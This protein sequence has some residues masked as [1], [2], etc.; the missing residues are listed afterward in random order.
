MTAITK[1]SP[2]NAAIAFL[3]VAGFVAY[4]AAF[5][6]FPMDADRAFRSWKNLCF[7]AGIILAAAARRWPF[8]SA[9][10]WAGFGVLAVILAVVTPVL[11]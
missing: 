9:L 1:T 6:M 2:R 11:P 4:L 5:A 7:P 10:C 8:I 3:W